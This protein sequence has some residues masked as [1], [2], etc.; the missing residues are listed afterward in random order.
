MSAFS[1]T[2]IQLP[3]IL[4]QVCWVGGRQDSPFSM[5]KNQFRFGATNSVG[6]HFIL[7]TSFISSRKSGYNGTKANVCLE[8]CNQAQ[9]MLP[10]SL[11]KR[12]RSY[13][14][15]RRSQDKVVPGAC[16]WFSCWGSSNTVSQ[17]EVPGFRECIDSFH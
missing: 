15:G 10:T 8:I 14:F 7:D 12:K 5:Q 17:L 4:T 16:Y 6:D 9:N 11:I 13:I 1:S 2:K 3:A